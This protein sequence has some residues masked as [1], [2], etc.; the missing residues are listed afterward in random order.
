MIFED[1]NL[2]ELL[3]MGSFPDELNGWRQLQDAICIRNHRFLFYVFIDI[4]ELC[5]FCHCKGQF[6]TSESEA[7]RLQQI[8]ANFVL[9]SNSP[10]YEQNLKWRF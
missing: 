1:Q 7:D 6:R 9:Q 4:V 2:I 8:N 3:Q 10:F 5:K